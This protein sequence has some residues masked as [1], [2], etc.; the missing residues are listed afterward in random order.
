MKSKIKSVLLITACCVAAAGLLVS[1]LMPTL[2]RS[3]S[4]GRQVA[5]APQEQS[6]PMPSPVAGFA[7][8]PL[9]LEHEI[10]LN[11]EYGMGE[12]SHDGPPKSSGDW[13]DMD[14]RL[15]VEEL[16]KLPALGYASAPRRKA[17]S[18][19]RGATSTP[20]GVADTALGILT[21]RGHGGNA[22]RAAQMREHAASGSFPSPDEE[23]WIIQ[24][25]EQ[26]DPMPRDD[27]P[28]CG[29]LVCKRE[30]KEIPLP[31]KHTDV[32]ASISGYI[33]TVEVTQQYH[34][35][36]DGKIEAVYVFPLPQNAAV[37]EFVMTVGERRIRGIIRER[38]EAERVYNEAKRQGYVASLLTQE[39]PNVFT[40][41]VANIE[42]GK[43]IDINI[44]YFNTLAYADG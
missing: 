44:K 4:G 31:L 6:S 21:L 22:S 14:T 35:P 34:N 33:A 40:Q 1:I 32:D 13:T 15:T 27:R 28:G 10:N 19:R 5:K 23:L 20:R 2:S 26:P 17:K 36:Y 41:S 29:T 7:P 43:N 24:R 37:N 8:S 38:K 39:R 11:T 12:S 25:P 30:D 18:R 42:S 9:P 16:E 3:R